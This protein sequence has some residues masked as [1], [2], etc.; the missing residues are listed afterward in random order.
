[1]A[2]PL[3]RATP[4]DGPDGG[5]LTTVN[6]GRYA[7]TMTGAVVLDYTYPNR[8]RVDPGG[9]ARDLTLPA[10]IEGLW[11]VIANFADASETITL[12]NAGGSTVET[13]DQNEEIEV[14][15]DGAAWA[16]FAIRTIAIT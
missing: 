11:Y 10:G 14:F 16:V 6:D 12:K 13:I 4:L 1:M 3:A 7:F 15:Y 5:A 2:G 9:S 8:L